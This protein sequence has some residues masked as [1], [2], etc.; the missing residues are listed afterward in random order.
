M[1]TLEVENGV[2][3]EYLGKLFLLPG[4]KKNAV[5]SC[6]RMRIKNSRSR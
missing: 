3:E 6:G 5:C 2:V 1:R 4:R